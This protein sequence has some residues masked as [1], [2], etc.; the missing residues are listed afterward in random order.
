MELPENQGLGGIF[1]RWRQDRPGVAITGARRL[2]LRLPLVQRQARRMKQPQ[3]VE[4]RLRSGMRLL[5]G[6]GCGFGGAHRG[7]RLIGQHFVVAGSMGKPLS[8]SRGGLCGAAGGAGRLS[9]DDTV[10]F[11]ERVLLAHMGGDT[12]IDFLLP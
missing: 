1:G 11:A 5:S 10:P 6:S 7:A 12:P 8:H 2:V 9:E 4:N 3:T